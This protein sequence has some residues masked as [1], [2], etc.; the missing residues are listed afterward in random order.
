MK[1]A[2]QRW[3]RKSS[4]IGLVELA[5]WERHNRGDGG[6]VGYEWWRWLHGKGTTE[7]IEVV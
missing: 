5:P 1:K 4:K 6:H 7:V 2:E 3:W